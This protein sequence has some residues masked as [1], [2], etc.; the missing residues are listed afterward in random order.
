MELTLKD[1]EI[2]KVIGDY[3]DDQ[4]FEYYASSVIKAA[5]IPTRKDLIEQVINDPKFQKEFTKFLMQYI[6]RDLMMD[7]VAD[8]IYVIQPVFNK[9]QD[10]FDEKNAID[11][12]RALAEADQEA[13]K[14]L[15][16][17]GYK[18]TQ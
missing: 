18:I 1:S 5:G 15:K 17:R 11:R 9:V 14:R 3:L 16:A 8:A 10:T 7:A 12:E 2:R 13:I 6:D 4:L